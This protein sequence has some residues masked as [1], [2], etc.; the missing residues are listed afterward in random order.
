MPPE[1]KA[2]ENRLRRMAARQEL[3]L[4]RSRRRD[5]RAVDYGTYTL[6]DVH[7]DTL[8]DAGERMTIDDVEE[9]LTGA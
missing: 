9:Y 3:R 7:G 6:V 8:V 2:R 5:R 4:V 1:D